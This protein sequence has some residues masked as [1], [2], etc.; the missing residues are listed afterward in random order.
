MDDG[1]HCRDRRHCTR[2]TATQYGPHLRPALALDI[3][4]PVGLIGL[5]AF[6][7]RAFFARQAA[8]SIGWQPSP[9]QFEAGIA[10][11]GRGIAGVIGAFASNGFHLGVS[12]VAAGFLW[13][14]AAGRVHEMIGAGNFAPGNAG[15]IFYTDTLTPLAV[16]ILLW[17]VA[18]RRW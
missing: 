17:V 1:G 14:A 12:V 7:G 15:P 18:R 11:F 16:F 3:F 10:N 9:L 13:G 2:S 6:V 8:V 4:F 5:W